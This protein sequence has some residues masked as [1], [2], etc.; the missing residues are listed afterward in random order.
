MVKFSACLHWLSSVDNLGLGGASFLEMLILYE[1]L[2]GERL[3]VEIAVAQN[4]RKRRPISVSV[5][6]FGPGTEV[7][8]SCRF[9]GSMFR[10]LTGLPEGM[11]RFLPC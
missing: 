1:T 10:A 4:R 8:R 11:E 7:W 3:S 5:V 9:L 6:P 2:A